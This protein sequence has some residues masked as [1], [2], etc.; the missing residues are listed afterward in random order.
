MMYIYSETIIKDLI[1]ARCGIVFGFGPIFMTTSTLS[2]DELPIPS[3]IQRSPCHV[4]KLY[5]AVSCICFTFCSLFKFVYSKKFWCT[6]GAPFC[7]YQDGFYRIRKIIN[8]QHTIR[9]QATSS[10][11]LLIFMRSYCQNDY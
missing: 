2:M 10:H 4:I 8:A 5:T 11:C 7:K 9:N 3:V 6:C 1:V